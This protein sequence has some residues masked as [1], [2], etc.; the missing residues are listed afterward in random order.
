MRHWTLCLIGLLAV[1]LIPGLVL[2]Q[3]YPAYGPAPGFAGGHGPRAQGPMQHG[4]MQGGAPMM[5]P[6]PC[7]PPVCGPPVC[8]PPPCEKPPMGI[9]HACYASYL[10]S[11]FGAQF[12]LDSDDAPVGG[13]V[14]ASYSYPLEGLVVGCGT[15]V[16]L[17]EKGQGMLKGSWLFPSRGHARTDYLLAAVAK[18][19][20]VVDIQWANVDLSG[21]YLVG[22]GNAAI[23]GGFRFDSFKT[24]FKEPYDLIGLAPAVFSQD[25]ADVSVVSYIPYVGV[26]V[27]NGS[28]EG[29]F[30][31]G[32]LAFPYLL[33]NVAFKETFGGVGTARVEANREFQGG[34]FLELF[35]EANRN[36]G[37][38]MSVGAFARWNAVHGE[39][40][41]NLDGAAIGSSTYRFRLDRQ[42]WVFGG[43]FAFS[44]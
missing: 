11:P 34:Y 23:I 7:P 14:G 6:G 20:W 27:Q 4:P 19:S 21:A 41:F 22:C 5:G 44:F 24:N 28:A 8:G 2:A 30:S 36:L 25:R 26:A 18:R 40:H 16:P 33:G 32:V 15:R 29:S 3:G 9:G 31:A 13:L 43:K 39:T 42:A 38:R 1:A 17:G 10:Y 37:E 35:G 12:R